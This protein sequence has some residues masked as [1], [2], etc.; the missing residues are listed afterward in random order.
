MSTIKT[1]DRIE[2]LLQ[3]INLGQYLPRFKKYG[4][5]DGTINDLNR[6]CLQISVFKRKDAVHHLVTFCTALKT[7]KRKNLGVCPDKHRPL[8][9]DT[10]LT[11]VDDTDDTNSENDSNND[12]ESDKEQ[13]DNMD[14][15][16][17]NL[18]HMHEDSSSSVLFGDDDCH[19]LD[20]NDNN[21]SSA[22]SGTAS[23]VNGYKANIARRR[24][25]DKKGICGQF[26]DYP[27]NPLDAVEE[28]LAFLGGIFWK[29]F[30]YNYSFPFLVTCQDVPNLMI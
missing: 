21:G 27:V 22:I 9:K 3:S 6:T 5:H 14:D 28:Y 2:S 4:F 23:I 8:A 29:N 24:E 7:F 19:I 30:A 12:D 18:Q 16:N 25:V 26:K 17:N 13:S 15:D 10:S 1:Y 20:L 11:E